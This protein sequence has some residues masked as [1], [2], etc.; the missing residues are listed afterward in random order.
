MDDFGYVQEVRVDTLKT[1]SVRNPYQRTIEGVGYFGVGAHKGTEINKYGSWSGM[2]YRC[3]NKKF[4]EKYP[5]YREC[6]SV[7]SWHCYQTYA[8]FYENCP[9]REPGWHLDKDLLVPG[10]KIYGPETCVYLPPSI[11][12]KLFYSPIRNQY[13]LRGVWYDV[14][15][16]KWRAIVSSTIDKRTIIGYFDS[17]EE[18]NATALSVEAEYF[19][20][21]AEEWEGRLDPRAIQGLLNLAEHRKGM[22]LT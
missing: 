18:A 15:C 17:K 6:Y 2:L 19:R 14:G 20:A 8:D 10:N 4:K 7:D 12:N 9:Y 13:G 5:S 1:G 3:Y 21:V 16:S 11:N 22:I